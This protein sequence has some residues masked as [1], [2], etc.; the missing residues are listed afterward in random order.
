MRLII[1][2]KRSLAERLVKTGLLSD[3]D[4]I[5]FTFSLGFFGLTLQ[6]N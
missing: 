1:L 2:E 4:Q 6:K 3:E 5:T